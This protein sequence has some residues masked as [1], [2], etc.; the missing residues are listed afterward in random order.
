MGV[1]FDEG[2]F[3]FYPL[4]QVNCLVAF[5][6][7]FRLCH[8]EQLD[9]VAQDR[10]VNFTLDETFYGLLFLAKSVAVDFNP[11]RPFS[12]RFLA[13]SLILLLYTQEPIGCICFL[14]FLS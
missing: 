12:L 10:P 8:F 4:L 5:F 13:H 2:L 6:T 3:E 11:H 14:Y 1:S 9:T 7:L